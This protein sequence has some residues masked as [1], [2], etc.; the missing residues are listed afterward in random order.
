MGGQAERPLILTCSKV[1]SSNKL[2]LKTPLG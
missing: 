1:A 2:K